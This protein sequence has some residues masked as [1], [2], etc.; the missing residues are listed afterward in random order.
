MTTVNPP[1]PAPWWRAAVVYQ[2]YPRSFADTDGDGIGD[3]RGVLDHLDYLVD[4][5]VG[6]L[7]LSPVMA[8]PQADHGYDVADYREIDPIFGSLT[9]MDELIAAAHER[10]LRLTLDFV[11]NHTSVE[12]DWFQSALAAGPGSP[13]RALSRPPRPGRQR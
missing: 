11:P 3:L 13:E 6:A 10:G 8:S 9:D 5:G 12:H 7:W 1:E 4:L 2:I